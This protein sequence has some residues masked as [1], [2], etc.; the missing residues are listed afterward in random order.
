MLLDNAKAAEGKSERMEEGNRRNGSIRRL[1]T[2]SCLSPLVEGPKRGEKEAEG[3]ETFAGG[4]RDVS[5]G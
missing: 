1:L 3:E 4:R 2:V 5:I